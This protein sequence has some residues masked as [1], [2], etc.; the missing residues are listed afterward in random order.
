MALLSLQQI[1]VSFGGPPVLDGVSLHVGRGDRIALV[2]RNGE[3]KSTLLKVIAGDQEMDSGEI[4]RHEVVRVTALAQEVPADLPGTVEEVVSPT[5]LGL[6][7]WDVAY[8]VDEA[9][10]HLGIDPYAEFAPLSGGQKRRALLARALV[11]HPDVLILD[12]PTNH[13]DLAAIDWLENFL[14]RFRG[15]VLFVTHD[16]AFQRRIATSVAQLDRGQL[17]R[18]DCTY[19]KFLVRREEAPGHRGKNTTRYSIKKLAQE[20]VWIRQGIKARRTR[21]EGRVKALEQ[22]RRDRQARREQGG[23]VKM[24]LQETEKSGRKVLVAEGINM[25]W[26]GE[27]VIKDFGVTFMRG[28][29]VGIIGPNGCGKST[30]LRILLGQLKPQT[31]TIEHG[32]KL[33]V[34]YFDQHRA[35][36]DG[37]KSVAENVGGDQEFVLVGGQRRHI[38]SYLEDFLFAPDRS[39]TPVKVLSG[40]ERNRLLLARLFLQPAN[41]LVL[42][43]PTNDLDADTLEL[44]ESLLLAFQG[45]LLL[46]S[47]DREL[48]NN[49]VTSTLV[50][51]GE[52]QVT[53]YV[54]GYDDWLEQRGAKLADKKGGAKGATEKAASPAAATASAPSP[55]PAPPR[56]K[57]NN[58][59]RQELKALPELID[60]LEAELVTLGETMS[61]PDFYRKPV[62]EVQAA[63][64]RSEA[65]PGLIQEA[66]DRWD[67]LSAE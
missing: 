44:L 18:W 55:S 57:L 65:L 53:E 45:T 16:R 60:T 17:T 23:Q 29:R 58:K 52:G 9:C 1:S 8:R 36:L 62:E 30:L 33:E 42:D 25:A 10:D 22:L 21:N 11:V 24:T 15:A 43:E 54:G 41:L 35:Q 31:G 32:T 51:E 37:E 14:Q 20:E 5:D 46:V 59:E 7:D 63:S 61:N 2:G 66:Y 49:V 38:M 67:V 12:E 34:A 47:H 40:G 39:R 6:E 27:P 19:D 64:A 26:E 28:D 48:L 13:L 3:G 50:F 56:K 4:V